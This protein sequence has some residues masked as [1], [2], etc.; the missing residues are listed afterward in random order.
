[1]VLV[2]S[3]LNDG[4]LLESCCIYELIPLKIR[5]F[6]YPQASHSASL[7][8]SFLLYKIGIITTWKCLLLSRVR[9]FATLWTVA[10][11]LLC[12]WDS[13]GKNTGVCCH[14]L[15]QGIFLTQGLNP[16]LLHCR[17]IILTVWATREAPSNSAYLTKF[18]CNHF[19]VILSIEAAK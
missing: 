3:N 19:S 9:L 11:R 5:V 1:M 13:P 18:K 10:P 14:F 15:L 12:P 8:L 4:V 7:S 17:Q 16:G 2:C 6:L